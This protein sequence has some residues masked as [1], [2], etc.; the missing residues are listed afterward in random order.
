MTSGDEVDHGRLCQFN[1]KRQESS[2]WALYL[3]TPN[4]SRLNIKEFTYYLRRRQAFSSL[5][6]A[7]QAWGGVDLQE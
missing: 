5:V 1:L 7:C 3:Q 6:V 4:K 2:E